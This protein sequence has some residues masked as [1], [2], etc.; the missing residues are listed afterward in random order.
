MFSEGHYNKRKK[1]ND[2]PAQ[3]VVWEFGWRPR[4][5]G[6][7]KPMVLNDIPTP[8]PFDRR[9]PISHKVDYGGNL[10]I[11]K[12]IV[13]EIFYILID[14]DLPS[15][16]QKCWWAYSVLWH[17][18]LWISQTRIVLSSLAEI[19]Y[20]PP[21][22]NTIPRTQLSWP[23]RVNRQTPTLTSQ[24]WQRKYTFLFEFERRTIHYSKV[25]RRWFCLESRKPKTVPGVHPFCYQ[26]QQLR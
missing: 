10:L 8:S 5:I 16:V 9:C 19:M 13:I 26:H 17:R 24:T 3:I 15:D 21:G 7:S 25:L 2:G 18:L 4:A 20:L 11:E 12:I 22:W 14:Y 1:N 23:L 6:K